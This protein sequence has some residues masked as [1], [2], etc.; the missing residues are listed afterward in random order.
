MSVYAR[1]YKRGVH[2]NTVQYNI[3]KKWN[4]MVHHENDVIITVDSKNDDG[5]HK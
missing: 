2:V 4:H 3:F 5:R 1:N